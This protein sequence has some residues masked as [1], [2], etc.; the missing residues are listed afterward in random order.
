MCHTAYEQN[1]RILLKQTVNN[2]DLNTMID[3]P[4][5]DLWKAD[6]LTIKLQSRLGTAFRP[7]LDTLKEIASI[8]ADIAGGLNIEGAE[9]V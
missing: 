3:D 6:E 2:E 8:M 4:G 5:S 7:S 1:V 9:K